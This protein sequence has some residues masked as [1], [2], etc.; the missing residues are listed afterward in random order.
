MSWSDFFGPLHL[1]VELDTIPNHTIGQKKS[2]FWRM[3]RGS[4]RGLCIVSQTTP[5]ICVGEDRRRKEKALRKLKLLGALLAVMAVMASSAVSPAVAS[6]WDYYWDEWGVC[7]WNWH[8]WGWSDLQCHDFDPWG[9][10]SWGH[11]SWGDDDDDWDDDD[12]DWGNK[13]DHWG[14]HWGDKDD[15]WSGNRWSGN[16]W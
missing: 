13:D 3:A 5:A 8:W 10:S 1:I 14:D 9:H 2:S 6:H 11:S 15:N 7:G 12:D 16:R 4:S